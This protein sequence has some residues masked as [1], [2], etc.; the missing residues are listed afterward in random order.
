[1]TIGNVGAGSGSSKVDGNRWTKGT[2]SSGAV[3]RPVN[4]E[5]GQGLNRNVS[6]AS[7][8]APVEQVTPVTPNTEKKEAPKPPERISRQISEADISDQLIK[9][10][11]P[12]TKDNRSLVMTML[13]Q[14]IPVSRNNFD[15][16][17]SI[18]N[19]A[20]G[21]AN[22]VV[23]AAIATSKG[24]AETPRA[25]DI[26]SGFL[27]QNSTLSK[28]LIVMREAMQE[29]LSGVKFQEGIL[30]RG[31]STGLASVLADLDRQ[32]KK[33]AQV[34]TDKDL[35]LSQLNRG[36]L[37][38]DLMTLSGFLNGINEKFIE[39]KSNAK[40]LGQ[41]INRLRARISGFTESLTS[42]A[43]ISKDSESMQISPTDKFA[44]WQVPNPLAIGKDID[45]LIR[46]DPT[47]KK[48]VIDEQKTRMVMRLETEELGEIAITMDI[49][50]HK[51]WY[52]FNTD[53]QATLRYIAEL[54]KNL[55]ERMEAIN[56]STMTIRTSRQKVD[57]KKL[58]IPVFNLDRISRISAEI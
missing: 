26:L 42:Q 19:G 21:H 58:L 18:K 48:G 35:A 46:K 39:G 6:G 55:R 53:R 52:I 9:L 40:E 54:E 41:Q 25:V 43:I 2:D 5:E 49:H 16:I 30:S 29:L 4:V 8:T 15:L 7:S 45:I 27:N 56:Y 33:L 23:S 20:S 22:D 14:G 3:Y 32:L 36:S 37:L 1:M 10:Q 17:A 12:L 31:L 47:K 57:L 50:D 24:L 51:I 44:Y 11:L 38:T 13:Q 34:A 28:Q